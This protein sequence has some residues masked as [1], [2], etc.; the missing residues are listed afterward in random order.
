MTKQFTTLFSI[1]LISLIALAFSTDYFL[2]QANDYNETVEIDDIRSLIVANK[3][4]ELI[5]NN[6]K[7]VLLSSLAW[8]TDIK[9]KL[10]SGKIVSLRNR[11]NQI[12]YYWVDDNGSV[13]ELGPISIT[14][15]EKN[16]FQQISV[17]FY[18]L[19]AVILALVLWPMFKDIH[20]LISVTKKFSIDHQSIK[21]NVKKGSLLYPLAESVES[22]SRQINRF[23]SLQRF[24]A[25]SVSHDI[26]TPLSRI[27]FL[28]TMSNDANLARSKQQIEQ[29]IDEIDR[30]TDEFIELAR[31]E[32]EHHLLKKHIS[33]Y[34]DWVYPLIERSK[35]IS[36]KSISLNIM[37]EHENLYHDPKFVE[38]ALQN[39]IQNALTYAEKEIIININQDQQN[40]IV[41]VHDDG[42]GINSPEKE[43]ILGLYERGKTSESKGSGYGIG[44]AFVNVIAEWHHGFVTI[45][46]SSLLNGAAVS[47]HLPK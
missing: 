28:N 35:S 45:E 43:R 30:L 33:S 13:I 2:E 18:C 19:F 6:T 44:L 42:I 25:S 41:T 5:L 47:I 14:L 38:R 21:T 31:L 46:P 24:L 34:K 29:E 8:P 9:Q 27:S 32:E 16:G 23:L 39:L 40:I 3:Q 37:T 10:I 36:E 12:F 22:M 17:I 20:R 26:R 4:G 7:T 1:I 11:Q 15:L